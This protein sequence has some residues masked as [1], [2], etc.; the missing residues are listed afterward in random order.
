[1]PKSRVSIV[2]LILMLFFGVAVVIPVLSLLLGMD[3]DS[4]KRVFSSPQFVTALKN[5][6]FVTTV[7]T[8]LS[9]FIS[10]AL[11]WCIARTGIVLKGIFSTVFTLPMLIPSMSHGMGLIILFGSNGI[12]TN[13]MNLK[14]NI[15]GFWGI[16]AGSVLYSFPVAFLMFLDILKYEDSAPYEAADV[17]GVPKRHQFLAITLPFLKKPLISIVFATFT[18]IVTDYGVPLMVGSQYITLPV[19]MYQE[20]IGLLDFSKG[21][22]IGTILLVPAVIAFILDIMNHDAG[23]SSFIIKQVRV[24]QNRWKDTLSFLFCALVSLA[25]LLP[26]LS[27]VTL[28][29]STKY[30]IDMAF[31]LDN[32]VQTFKL[33]GGTY[34]I[35]S[36]EIA[37]AVSITGI[38]LAFVTAYF[39]AR[40]PDRFS[41]MLH[42]I[43]ITS[44]AIPG[45]VLGLSYVT[46]FHNTMLYGTLLILVMVNL[47]HFFAS[48]YLMVYNSL[49]KV[50]SHLEEVGE[51]LGIKRIYLIR[52]VILPQVRGSLLEMFAY[53][54]VNCMM[55]ISAVAFLADLSHKPL[56]LM[57]TQFEAQMLIECASF[58]SLLILIVNLILKGILYIV[59]R[60]LAEKGDLTD[61]YE[62]TI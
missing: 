24:R 38:V 47:I 29:F 50:N 32:I 49:R 44:L 15:Y 22:V 60:K 23:N 10:F 11:A 26:V 37:L 5:S 16:V 31:T 51:T 57:I 36:L 39:T 14:W 35:N 52:D 33:Q 21:A 17:L 4:L 1:M 12:L 53:F 2:K 19:M 59:K 20:V 40:V 54:F 30:P 27:F 43:S 25:V 45:I 62:R 46:A 3:V 56:S 7:S 9:I 55:T 34:L 13:L 18:L 42:M 48:P 58:V 6:F 28:T 41:G 8:L 61:A